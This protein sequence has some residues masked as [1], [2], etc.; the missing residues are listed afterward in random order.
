MV[1]CIKYRSD[2]STLQILSNPPNVLYSAITIASI[3]F[4][5][6]LLGFPL[7]YM[8]LTVALSVLVFTL[9]ILL[10]NLF[11]T[12]NIEIYISDGEIIYKHPSG[13]IKAE[14]GEIIGKFGKEKVIL[15]D[16][17]ITLIKN[18]LF[19][20]R[21]LYTGNRDIYLI[22]QGASIFIKEHIKTE[23]AKAGQQAS[24]AQDKD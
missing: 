17:M 7:Y 16:K 2:L 15:N 10:P 19:D 5:A 18:G 23:G 11:R 3:G 12:K 22:D 8:G 20:C 14:R 1:N 13:D 9:G 4:L 21:I 6:F 24:K